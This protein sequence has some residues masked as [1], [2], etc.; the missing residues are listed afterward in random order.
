M[1]TKSKLMNPIQEKF[2]RNMMNP[3]KFRWFLLTKLPSVLFWGVKVNRLDQSY[4]ELS[5]PYRWSTKNPF[6]SIYFA[7]LSGTAELA[8]G[9][10]CMLHLT[11]T[12]SF[13]MLVT[14]FEANFYKK[15]T[16]T[17][18]FICKDGDKLRAMLNTLKEPGQ[19]AT[20]IMEVVGLNAEG[21]SIGAFKLTWSFKKKG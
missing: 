17:T 4:C 21:N 12:G 8:S 13:S 14:G 11:G 16:G 9:I 10:L 3:L 5:L 15:A 19:T 1:T 2:A 7:A 6:R 18:R 20:F